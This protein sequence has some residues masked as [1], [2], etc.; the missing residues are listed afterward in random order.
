MFEYAGGEEGKTVDKKGG[1]GLVPV[2]LLFSVGK[3]CAKVVM[4]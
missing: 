2:L 3:I 4:N 1:R